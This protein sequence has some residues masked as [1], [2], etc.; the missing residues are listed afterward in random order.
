[1][2]VS[3]VVCQVEADGAALRLD[4]DRIRIWFPELQVREELA[5][6]VSFLRAHRSEV[7]ELL[8]AR[9]AIPDMPLGV[10]LISWKIEDPPVAIETCAIVV[11]AVLFARR[12]LE[13]LRVALENPRRWVGWTVPQLIERLAQVGVIVALEAEGKLQ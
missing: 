7:A 12:T 11:D 1:M 9:Q 10:R 8:R 2:R 13:Q 5:G 4:G 6:E 3:D